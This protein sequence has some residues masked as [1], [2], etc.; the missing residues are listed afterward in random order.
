MTVKLIIPPSEE[1]VTVAEVK[2]QCRISSDDED[3]LLD[4]YIKAA[5]ERAEAITG[6]AF[7]SQT[8]E[9]ALDAFP[10]GEILLPILP[11]SV[12]NSVAYYD[13]DGA[14]QVMA[15]A[16]YVLDN[17]GTQRHWAIPAPTVEWPSTV[18]AANAVRVSFRAGYGVA[19][20]V[21]ASI[22]SWILA[23]VGSMYAQRETIQI[24]NGDI[25]GV[26]FLD[27]LLDPFK[28][29]GV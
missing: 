6:L 13:T 26:E 1:P 16:D 9:L 20:D 27:G 21:P 8:W 28:V 12:I 3:A 2:L 29:I 25:K 5:R 18:D 17:Y 10:D 7:I 19:A 24:G 11:V 22:R 14:M 23:A 15:A 4:I